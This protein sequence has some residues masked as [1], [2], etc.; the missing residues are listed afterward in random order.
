ML[1]SKHGFVSHPYGVQG[2]LF[3]KTSNGKS[4]DELNE[5]VR[6]RRGERA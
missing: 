2:P 5:E 6:R 3:W 4:L 1:L